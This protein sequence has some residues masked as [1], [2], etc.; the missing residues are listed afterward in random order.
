MY[1]TSEKNTTPEANKVFEVSF[2]VCNRVGGIYR[3]LESKADK[4]T[5]HYGN[6]YF[7]V[8]PYYKEKARGEFREEAA[9]AEMKKVFQELA[10]EGIR[11]H[12]GRW[13]VKGKPLTILIDFNDYFY[14]T[15]EIKKELWDN[16]KIDSLYTGH[17]FN[18][19]VCWSYAAGRL[20]RELAAE[21]GGKKT[22]AHFHEW[23]SGAGL[24]HLK[25]TNSE[26]KT[27]FTTHATSLGRTLAFHSINFYTMLDEID[28]DKEA[29]THQVFPKHSIEKASARECDVFT[30]VSEI[31][32]IEA[33]KFL[34]RKPDVILPNGLD[35][36]K[37]LSFEDI[38]VKHR[39]QRRRMRNFVAS[40]FF[41]YYT[42]DLE[43]TLFYFIIGRNEFRAKGV[44]VFIESLGRLNQ[45][46]KEERSKR[47][48]IAFLFIPSDTRGI[49]PSLLENVE[50]F[51]D[52]QETLEGAMP[53]I[54]ERITYNILRNKELEKE[55][56][57]SEDYL[58]DIEK[59]MYRMKRKEEHPSLST[60]HLSSLHDEI[61]NSLK[62]NN[63][64]N[65][66]EDRVKV[67]YYPIY[68]TG[69]DGLSNLSYE[70][71]LEACHLGVFPSF[72]EP[73]GY[74]PL[75]AAALGVSSV[76]TDLA[77]FGKFCDGLPRKKQRPG[78]YVLKREGKA[79]Q[80]VVGD[81]YSFL[82]EF[83]NTTR[84][85]RVENKIEAR[86][87]ASQADW[88]SFVYNYIDAHNKALGEK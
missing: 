16:F 42:F 13:L 57:I 46:M 66:E 19:P 70:E 56:L 21:Y 59:K 58:L 73:W 65:R 22:I 34:E 50:Y 36:E 12:Y 75:E 68:L 87:I 52:L 26:A 63:L 74:T 79:D 69:H 1:P 41:P 43:E 39:L 71:A 80:E 72:Y 8:G 17:D 44:D 32:G 55:N 40:Y 48:V 54:E 76:T 47:T 33:E 38:V 27:V 10:E 78:I 2:E 9:P 49:N 3:V 84:R 15:D 51:R 37:F 62:N 20:I 81:L 35:I 83:I 30:T 28:P 85:E 53:D 25:M 86:K 6:N 18:E 67:I 4:M 23:L 82:Y 31:T 60:H 14:K 29:K 11:C 5:Y 24:L 7:L 64:L 77:G 88:R 61:I 45:K